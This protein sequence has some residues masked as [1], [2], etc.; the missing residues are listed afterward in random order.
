MN[1]LIENWLLVVA[2]LV[3]GGMLLAPALRRGAQGAGVS[4]NEA[5]R[6][7]NRERAVVVDVC[8]ATEFA[9][10]HVV[11]ARNVPMANLAKSKELPGNKTLPLIVVCA[12]G[13]RASKAATELRAMGYE[14][15]QVLSG[16]MRAW[17]EANLP[18][19]VSAR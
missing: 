2:A 12:S 18:V 7:I 5:V 17:R 10:G 6:L 1:F 3:S 4:P 13:M 8:E 11:G 16:G 19:E 9:A 14:Q 15:A